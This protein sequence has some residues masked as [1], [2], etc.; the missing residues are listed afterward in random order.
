M[1][2]VISYLN[3]RKDI[4]FSFS[5][6]N[7]VDAMVLSLLISIDFGASIDEKIGIKELYDNFNKTH[8][9]FANA[10]SKDERRAEKLKAFKLVAESLRY[11]KLVLEKYEKSIEEEER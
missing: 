9:A 11:K 6:F 10:H 7:E 4:P 1:D 3:F 2:N 8:K 5:K